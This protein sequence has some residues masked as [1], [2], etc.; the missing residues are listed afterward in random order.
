[1]LLELNSASFLTRHILVNGC[2]RQET[3]G[4]KHTRRHILN[5][6]RDYT[7]LVLLHSTL[8]VRRAGCFAI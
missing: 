6:L 5:K 7:R 2:T 1:M 4:T 3:Y 8:R